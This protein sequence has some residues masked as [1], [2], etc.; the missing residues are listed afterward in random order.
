MAIPHAASG[1]LIDIAPL[2][3]RVRDTVSSTLIRAE[4]FEVFRL[5]LPAGK[6]TQE[7]RA[8]GLITIQCLEGVVELDA[9]GQAQTLTPGT[10]VYLADAE[11]H[12]VTALEDAS[13]LITMLL[14]RA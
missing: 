9:H 8:A 4:H 10:L 14:H 2:G 13:L 6:S 3:E 7:H 1:E 11:P 12:A 5:V